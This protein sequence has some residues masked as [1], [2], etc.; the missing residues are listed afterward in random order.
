MNFQKRVRP[1]RKN[2]ATSPAFRCSCHR[3]LVRLTLAIFQNQSPVQVSRTRDLWHSFPLLRSG[4]T[5]K[6]GLLH[7]A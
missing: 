6:K 4:N 3:S 7:A 2:R 5:S 1:F